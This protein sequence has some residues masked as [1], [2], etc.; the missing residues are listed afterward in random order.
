VQSFSGGLMASNI[1]RL[2]IEKTRLDFLILPVFVSRTIWKS[3]P[4][5]LF[6]YRNYYKKAK[7]N[8]E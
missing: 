3:Q 7:E 6:T 1:E 4:L 2:K 8:P 5:N